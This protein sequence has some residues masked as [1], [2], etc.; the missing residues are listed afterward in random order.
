MQDEVNA[1]SGHEKSSVGGCLVS[2]EISEK[3]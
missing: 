3:N 1:G 2:T